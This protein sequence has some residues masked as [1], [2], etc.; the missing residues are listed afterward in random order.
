MENPANLI[1][2]VT[3]NLIQHY[4]AITQDITVISA[5]LVNSQYEPACQAMSDLAVQVLGEIPD[6]AEMDLEKIQITMW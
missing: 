4:I 3:D 2:L 6:Y 5:D 1:A